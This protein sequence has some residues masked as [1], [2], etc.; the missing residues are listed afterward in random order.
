MNAA[1]VASPFADARWMAHGSVHAAKHQ[2]YALTNILTTVAP[3]LGE[4]EFPAPR[5]TRASRRI[6]QA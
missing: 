1:E 2:C 6:K 3:I 4:A 5:G